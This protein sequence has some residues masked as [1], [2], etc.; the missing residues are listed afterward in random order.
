MTFVS[1]RE[2]R[3]WVM[4]ALLV[5]IIYA[6][7]GVAR[8]WFQFLAGNGAGADMFLLVSVFILLYIVT[9]ELKVFPRWRETLIALGIVAVYVVAF[10]QIDVMEGRI[11]LIMYGVVALMIYAA[12]LER[13]THGRP[14]PASF[15]VAIA[16]TV[17]LGM[18]DEL[19]QLTLP[20]RVFDKMDILYNC[21]ASVMAVM[22]N[23]SLRWA[24]RKSNYD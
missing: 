22:T 14:V 21:L 23:A 1:R 13:A 11:H 20:S 24:R 6:T 12:L 18:I 7:L 9:H 5:L 8:E 19:I 2:R 10:M 17:G 4:T 3:L 15:M 16:V